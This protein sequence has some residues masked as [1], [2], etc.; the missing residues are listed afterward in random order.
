MGRTKANATCADGIQLTTCSETVTKI[1]T[2]TPIPLF[3][4]E[5]SWSVAGECR[6]QIVSPKLN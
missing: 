2:I 1:E 4:L 3:Y 5:P 6:G